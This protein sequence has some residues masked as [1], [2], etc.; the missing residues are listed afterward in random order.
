M[1]PEASPPRWGNQSIRTIVVLGLGFASV[2]FSVLVV[3]AYAFLVLAYSDSAF[4][5]YSYA[6]L[7][8]ILSLLCVSPLALL[9]IFGQI[10]PWK[11]SV[12]LTA[13]TSIAVL[14]QGIFTIRFLVIGP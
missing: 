2:I 9:N 13:I 6:T 7:L 5:G 4:L 3:A 1:T 11:Y 14:V 12:W 8:L 10:K